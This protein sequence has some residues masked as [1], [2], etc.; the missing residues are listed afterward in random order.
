MEQPQEDNVAVMMFEAPP[1][2]ELQEADRIQM[3]DELIA[4]KISEGIAAALPAILAQMSA[5]QS[6][7]GQFSAGMGPSSQVNMSIA[8]AVNVPTKPNYL[9]HYRFDEAVNGKHQLIDVSKIDENGEFIVEKLPDGKIN[10]PAI[11][12]GQYVHFVGGHFYATKQ[13]EVDY[14]EWK[15]KNDPGCK[16]YEDQGGTTIPC[17]VMNCGM[18]FANEAGLNAHMK[19]THG[20]G[21]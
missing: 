9:K 16:I 18:Y 11:L 21:R 14:V 10:I 17:G 1:D 6:T 7:D 13:I 15:M 5:N 20:V 3:T 12:K 4:R 2:E 19:A 8:G